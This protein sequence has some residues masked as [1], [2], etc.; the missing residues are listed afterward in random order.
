MLCAA[1]L[2]Y[3]VPP[4]LCDFVSNV[5]SDRTMLSLMDLFLLVTSSEAFLNAVF[6]PCSLFCYLL[7][8]VPKTLSTIMQ[9]IPTRILPFTDNRPAS[10]T[11]DE[12]RMHQ[13]CSFMSDL[14]ADSTSITQ[15]SLQFK[16]TRFLFIPRKLNCPDFQQLCK[17][18]LFQTQELNIMVDV[19]V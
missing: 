16:K 7:T 2:S 3:G 5:L 10:D 1:N 18:F 4:S 14:E 15:N 11:L 12:S 17:G 19:S 8:T 9:M 6:F 13:T